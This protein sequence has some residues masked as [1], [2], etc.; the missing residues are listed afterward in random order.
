VPLITTPT[1]VTFHI[2]QCS[3]STPATWRK[4]LITALSKKCEVL[5][6]DPILK[7]ILNN[8][9]TCWLQQNPFNEG[10]SP[11]AHQTL[12]EEQRDI[13]WKNVFLA[14]ISVQWSHAAS[15]LH[16]G[17]SCGTNEIKTATESSSNDAFPSFLNM[18][19]SILKDTNYTD[20]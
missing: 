19:H 6:T 4:F 3:H 17:S 10:V 16:Y 15:P 20:Q 1:R 13:G 12:L 14:R 5:K 18:L 9:I 8:G 7:S 2:I 11:D